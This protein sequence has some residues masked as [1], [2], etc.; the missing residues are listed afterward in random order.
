MTK[1]LDYYLQLPY[2]VEIIPSKEGGFVATIPDLPGCITQVDNKQVLLEMIEDAKVAWIE[3][4]LEDND[5]I[6]EPIE[7]FSGK[8]NVR[9][10]KSLHRELV[11]LADQEKVSLN[12]CVTYLLSIGVTKKKAI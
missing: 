9:V 5:E 10:P 4:A 7:D 2:R 11:Q 8:F 3:D 12:Q 6:P 1:N